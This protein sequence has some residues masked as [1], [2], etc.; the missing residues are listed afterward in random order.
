MAFPTLVNSLDNFSKK[1]V[2]RDISWSFLGR[3]LCLPASFLSSIVVARYLGPSEL[4]NYSYVLFIISF[5]GLIILSGLPTIIQKYFA[6]ETSKMRHAEIG[7]A[8]IFVQSCVAAVV[9]LASLG[10]IQSDILE[11]VSKYFIISIFSLISIPFFSIG[12]SYLKAKLKFGYLAI[13]N[14][15]FVYA[16]FFIKLLAVSLSLDLNYFFLIYVCGQYFLAHILFRVYRKEVG[17]DF[18]IKQLKVDTIKLLPESLP[19]L[20]SGIAILFNMKVDQALLYNMISPSQSGIYEVA[21]KF[22]EIL[23]LVPVTVSSIYF[24]RLV[25]DASVRRS[26]IKLFRVTL[27]PTILLTALLILVAPMLINIT[28]G[29]KYMD[30]IFPLRLV[31]ISGLSVAIGSVWSSWMIINQKSYFTFVAQAVAVGLNIALNFCLIPAYGIIGAALAT[32]MSYTIS[33]LI[34]MCLYRRNFIFQCL[35]RSF[36]FS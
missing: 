28:Y 16:L 20:L 4:G 36:A 29:P 30:A 6:K 34:A 17:F 33:N 5:L 31:A 22:N 13:A 11:G 35:F 1:K 14:V 27:F 15:C 24:P 18:N 3:L 7:S 21:V 19:L 9:C 2:I 10:L 23:F 26:W 32:L 12:D 25:N 8:G